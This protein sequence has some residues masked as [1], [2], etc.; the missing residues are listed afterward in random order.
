MARK[1]ISWLSFLAVFIF[2][3]QSCVHDEI[4]SSS[5]P[6]SKEY[7]SKSLWKEDEKYIKNVMKVYF[8]NESEIKK[9]SGTPYWDYAT[10]VN[11][12]DESFLMV[13]VVEGK[14]VVSVLKVPRH[15]SKIYFYYTNSNEDLEFFQGFVFSKNK[16]ALKFDTTSEVSKTVCSRQWISIW[17]PDNNNNPDGPGHWD[18]RSVIRCR[19]E[20]DQC[21]G[22]VNEFGQCEGGGGSNPGYPYP[23]GGGPSEPETPKTPCEKTKD[24]L[25]KP[26]VKQGVNNVTAQALKTLSDMKTG[27]IGF[28]EPKNGGA[29]I[30]ADVNQDHKVIFND[31]TDSYGGY[32]NHTAEGTHM[33]SPPDIQTLLGF[34]AAQNNVGD[35]YFGMI[36]AEWCTTCPDPKNILNYVIQYTGEASDLGVGGSHVYTEAQIKQ[37]IKDYQKKVD[38]LLKNPLYS[39][40][41]GAKLSQVG[42][43]K[44]FFDTLKNMGLDGKV[45][46]QRVES[47]GKVNNITLESNGLPI[48]TPCP[49]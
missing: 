13:P 20:I 19:Q 38:K 14:T 33:F 3:L 39:V 36:A 23:G 12:F 6:A 8:E 17:I 48:G 44:L 10:T 24:I 34:A 37:Y 40:N 35:A 7:H 1:I 9:T 32:H 25:N 4:Y 28:K 2:I 45:N 30:P 27:E 15:G 16:K 18:T 29:P 41:N 47:T 31:V 46:L 11:N 42:L 49:N 26:N 43:E 22:V 21:V 5:D